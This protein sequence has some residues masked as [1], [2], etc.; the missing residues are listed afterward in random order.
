MQHIISII[1][2]TRDRAESLKE[3]L[4]AI[5]ETEVPSD[6][7]A[8]VLVVDNG[9]LDRTRPVV[10][11]AKLW[12]RAPRYV[13][14]P[15]LGLSCA[16]NSGLVA[17]RGE[18]LLWTDDDVRPG[19]TW[20]EAMCR[21][22]LDGRADAVAGR[23]KLASDLERPWLQPWHRVCLAVDVPAAGDFDLPG[24]NMALSRRV[25]DK[26]PA[27]DLELGAG[28]LGACEEALF[29]Q[30]LLRAGFRLV[31]AGED[32][33]VV[34][35]CGEHRLTRKALVDAFMQRGRCQAYIDYHWKHR[36]VWFPTFHCGQSSLG[37]GGLRILQRLLGDCRSVIGRREA[38]WLWRRSYYL[39]M[40]VESQRPRQYEQFGLEKPVAPRPFETLF[41]QQKRRAA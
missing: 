4:R 12:D 14:E 28:A 36:T 17:A 11:Q 6:L 38:R 34:R 35:H 1:I 31:A 2:C 20:I 26:V 5:G 15:R 16:R 23:I 24:A 7:A 10:R 30:Q 29:S 41:A 21:P 40:I 33:I 13:Y 39:Q 19:H 18:V 9:S 37:L 32:S 27:F 22:V 25:L 3:T 8:E